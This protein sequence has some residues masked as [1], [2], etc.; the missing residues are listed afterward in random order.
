MAR[1]LPFWTIDEKIFSLKHRISFKIIFNSEKFLNAWYS[2]HKKDV[3]YSASSKILLICTSYKLSISELLTENWRS[4]PDSKFKPALNFQIIVVRRLKY[5]KYTCGKK[6]V[7]SFARTFQSYN[8]YL[9]PLNR[10]VHI[11]PH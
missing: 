7:Y 5:G 1:L 2:S 6:W 3:Y 11:Y 8:R 9:H 4:F 10:Q